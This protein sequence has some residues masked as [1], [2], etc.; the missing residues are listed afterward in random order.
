MTQGEAGNRTPV[1]ERREGMYRGDKLPFHIAAIVRGGDD[2]ELF[3]G[4]T[5]DEVYHHILESVVES[6]ADYLEGVS[7]EHVNRLF[8][9]ATPRA[10]VEEYFRRVGSTGRDERL[11]G[12][13]FVMPRIA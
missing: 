5:E 10:Q 4:D 12:G 6:G 8:S 11:F 13:V 7:E 1:P 9:L 2:V 3:T